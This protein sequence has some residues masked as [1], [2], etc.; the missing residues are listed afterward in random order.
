MQ[1][2]PTSIKLTLEQ[3]KMILQLMNYSYTIP[4]EYHKC[5]A[6]AIKRNATKNLSDETVQRMVEKSQSIAQSGF[7]LRDDSISLFRGK[8]A[9]WLACIEYNA[10]KNSGSVIMTIVN[11]DETS[12]ADLLHFIKVGDEFKA[13]PGPDIKSGGSTY[14]FNQWKK[15][16]LDRHDIPMVDFDGVLTTDEGL[17]Q[18]KESERIELE[19]L[20]ER[21]PRKQPIPSMWSK[22]D[23]L[24]LRM[25]YFKEVLETEGNFEYSPEIVKILKSKLANKTNDVL[26]QSDWTEFNKK[27][28]EIFK[29]FNPDDLNFQEDN[30]K[31]SDELNK[32][33]DLNKP[34]NSSKSNDVKHIKNSFVKT[35]KKVPWKRIAKNALKGLII[36][37]T[38][39]G[40]Y[41]FGSK[42]IKMDK[43]TINNFKKAIKIDKKTIN[44]IKKSIK[45]DKNTINGVKKAIKPDESTI[46][47]I[48][49]AISDIPMSME[50]SENI[51]S[52]ISKAP[53]NGTHA[54][55]I[56]HVVSSYTRKNGTK[57][58]SYIRGGKKQL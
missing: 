20:Y 6:E 17:R 19:Q 39:S 35:T 58:N 24:R 51:V 28:K 33:N 21:Y 1:D 40:A 57:V 47:L 46:N 7:L 31:T 5:L 32:S 42:V 52:N 26:P 10:M 43:N 44:S 55:P 41:K 38:F 53:L 16:V 9:E 49:D 25:D 50:S 3:R 4:P 12:K 11:P 45:I 36:V 30:N 13:V 15:I 23:E 2:K 37:G 22:Q 18:L 54:S 56:Q 27:C 8:F 34:N 14:V 29:D 48:K